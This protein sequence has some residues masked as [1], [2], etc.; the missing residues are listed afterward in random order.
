[1]SLF[2]GFFIGLRQ[3]YL[4]ELFDRECSYLK[5]F[6]A[7]AKLIDRCMGKAAVNDDEYLNGIH[8]PDRQGI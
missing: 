4:I 1:M 2:D 5:T 6:F 7:D 8:H 3:R